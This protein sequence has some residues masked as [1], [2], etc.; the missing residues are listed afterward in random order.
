MR[1]SHQWL[2]HL[3]SR[4]SVRV[5]RSGRK[6]RQTASG[7]LLSVILTSPISVKM[8]R[9]RRKKGQVVVCLLHRRHLHLL[10]ELPLHRLFLVLPQLLHHHHPRVVQCHL[11]LLRVVLQLHLQCRFRLKTMT[12]SIPSTISGR[13]KRQSNCSGGTCETVGK[14]RYGMRCSQLR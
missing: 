12:T 11:L 13:R 5:R 8:M 9:R 3:R 4:T 10:E 7:P 2:L 1:Q 6:L 14:R